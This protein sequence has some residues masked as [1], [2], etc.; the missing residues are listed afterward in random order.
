MVVNHALVSFVK[1]KNKKYVVDIRKVIGF[2]PRHQKDFNATKI[3]NVQWPVLDEDGL[4]KEAPYEAKILCMAEDLKSLR[5]TANEMKI[6]NLPAE[7]AQTQNVQLSHNHEGHASRRR[8]KQLRDQQAAERQKV[9][10]TQSTVSGSSIGSAQ[11]RES[12]Y[13]KSRKRHS[14]GSHDHRPE[15][16]TPPAESYVRSTPHRKRAS[17]SV[18]PSKSTKEDLSHSG[19]SRSS[20]FQDRG[21]EKKKIPTSREKSPSVCFSR[22]NVGSTQQRKQDSS[23]TGRSRSSAHSKPAKDCSSKP[24][25]LSVDE[26][27][28]YI[29]QDL[30]GE[31]PLQRNGQGQVSV[32]LVYCRVLFLGTSYL[33]VETWGPKSLGERSVHGV[34]N[35]F[36]H[37]RPTKLKATPAKLNVIVGFYRA[38]LMHEGMSKREHLD[39][40][41]KNMMQ[42][43]MK[44]K[45]QES[46]PRASK[47]RRA[48]QKEKSKAK[49]QLMFHEEHHSWSNEDD[50]P[51]IS[52]QS[53]QEEDWD[54]NHLKNVGVEVSS[55][56]H[57]SDDNDDQ[58]PLDE[59]HHRQDD[60]DQLLDSDEDFSLFRKKGSGSV[61]YDSD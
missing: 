2:K 50:P 8:L 56:D 24:Q 28:R 10:M 23:H 25:T 52:P 36:D 22:S 12:V 7:L 46:S 57:Q 39:M 3:Y 42:R 29:L 18:S 48:R 17:E 51:P 35:P 14:S 34:K 61:N 40:A 37:S 43:T 58:E 6:R 13:L 53:V 45:F 27:A 19:S 4:K 16:M 33:M 5:Y 55:Y 31:V 41:C 11:R 47:N 21:L 44:D 49:R 20:G 1:E 54:D 9:L 38:R 59:G 30:E 60:N 32:Q 15:K 26:V